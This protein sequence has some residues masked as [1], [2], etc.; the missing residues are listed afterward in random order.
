MPIANEA[1]ETVAIA[2]LAECRRCLSVGT[3]LSAK[4][5]KDTIA[6]LESATV[7]SLVARADVL[8]DTTNDGR[9]TAEAAVAA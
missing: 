1:T 5:I 9:S 7:N 6:Q 8:V 4:Y 2:L 3:S